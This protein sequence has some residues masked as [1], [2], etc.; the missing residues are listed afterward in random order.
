MMAQRTR[1]VTFLVARRDRAVASS[2]V[3]VLQLSRLLQMRD[4]G[5]AVRV[6]SVGGLSLPRV[7]RGETVVVNYSVWRERPDSISELT[8]RNRV[9]L[10]P[11]DQRLPDGIAEFS[12]GIL[13]PSIQA[14]WDLEQRFPHAEVF[15]VG[16]HTNFEI[17]MVQAQQES[18]AVAYVGGRS[19]CRFVDT[20]ESRAGLAVVETPY[21]E[22]P[23]HW[24]GRLRD[25]SAQFAMRQ[26][27]PW[28]GYKFFTKGFL[29]AQC[30]VPIITAAWEPDVLHFLTPDYP[31]LILEDS[32][33]A[34]LD[35]LEAARS[36]FR[37][38][39]WKRARALMDRMY[40]MSSHAAVADQ[41]WS[42]V[43]G[44]AADTKS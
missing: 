25:Y 39:D 41:I 5:L 11:V 24:S 14:K 43:A 4:R 36:A 23:S 20:L 26:P 28:D 34:A 27:Q 9:L 2:I 37:T 38:Q 29:A 12:H 31:F 17:P 33:S 30:G 10:D 35:A 7:L 19:N 15:H 32:E 3:R 16:W 42:A 8:K 1:H 21:W 18:W 40:R 44:R 22:S 6:V 13:A